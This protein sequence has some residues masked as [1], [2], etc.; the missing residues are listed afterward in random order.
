MGHTESGGNATIGIG[1]VV[2]V[3][4]VAI[5]VDVTE[6]RRRVRSGVDGQNSTTKQ[7]VYSMSPSSSPYPCQPF[8]TK[9]YAQDFL[10]DPDIRESHLSYR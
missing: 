1:R 7:Q 2:V 10:N 3:A 8:A 4:D 6:I 9:L 5:G